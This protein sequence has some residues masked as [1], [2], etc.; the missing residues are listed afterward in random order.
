MPL[1]LGP[2]WHAFIHGLFQRGDELETRELYDRVQGMFSRA[3]LTGADEREELVADIATGVL[4]AFDLGVDHRQA[5]PVVHLVGKL[6]DY[7]DMFLLPEI[8]WTERR[9]VTQ[10]WE[11][12]DALNHQRQFVED[13]PATR[14]QLGQAIVDFLG[15]I[16]EACPT[17]AE[18]RGDENDIT[19]ATDLVNNIAGVGSVTEQALA[20]F[21]DDDLHEA[22]LFARLSDRLERN[23]VAASG[24]NP[25]DPR[26][27]NRAPKPPSKSEI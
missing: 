15:P 9:S 24:G 3:G 8:D 14:E 4:A 2:R 26:G 16:F 7:E 13:F 1:H 12:R 10:W 18:A 27:F 23:L 6:L 21:F 25:A 5:T 11:L 19:I 17:L 20:T 22:G